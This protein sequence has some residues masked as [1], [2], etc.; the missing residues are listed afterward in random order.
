MQGAYK[1]SAVVLH[2]A[3]TDNARGVPVSTRSLHATCAEDD[4]WWRAGKG[5]KNESRM[6]YG[7]SCIQNVDARI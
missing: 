7:K 2:I 1:T 3:N 6:L 4:L 5:E